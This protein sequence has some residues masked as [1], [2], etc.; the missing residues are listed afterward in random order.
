MKL[1]TYQIKTH[2]GWHQRLGAVVPEGIVD[3]NFACAW[4]LSQSGETSPQRVADAVLPNNMLEFLQGGQTARSH[5]IQALAAVLASKDSCIQGVNEETI[6]HSPEQVG[7]E[8]PIPNPASLRDFFGFE[9]H[10][11]AGFEKRGEPMPQEWYEIP[12]Y[13]K[14]GHQNIIGTGREV[15]WPSFTE[16]FDYEL[17]MA[18]VI[19]KRGRNVPAG[20]AM[21][22]IA[23]YTIMND[24]S[25]R[26]I[27]RKEMR[28]RLGPAKGKD[29][30]TAIGPV[31]VTPDEIGDAYNLR[32]TARVNGETWSEG[33][34][35]TMFWKFE[36]MI[37]FLSRDDTIVPGD[38][39][40]SGTVGKGC[41]LELNRWV[42]P[43][44]TIELEIEKI[45][46]LQNKVIKER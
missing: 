31:L 35:R 38:V 6:I 45:G 1:C 33:N 46:V 25:A 30:C 29:W 4:L 13:Y 24:F 7:L 26:D 11:K 22:Y 3:L 32:M 28:V 17:E 36:Q 40:G 12:V 41:G 20:E 9:D 15:L 10:V 23:G 42:K 18:I 8:A 27:Q 21:E 19:G 44:D 2:L 14:S 37:E 16:K 39:I 34:S 5:A 43:G